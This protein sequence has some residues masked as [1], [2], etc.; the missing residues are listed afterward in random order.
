ML[1][2]LEFIE[3]DIV[4]DLFDGLVGPVEGVSDFVE[5]PLSFDVLSGFVSRSND[6]HE[7]SFMDLSIFE[8]PPVLY[9]ITLSTPPSPTSHIFDINDEIVL[10]DSDDD[11]SSASDLGPID[12]RVSLAI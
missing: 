4:D 2:L 3:G 8:Y 10:H 7:S 5:P 9:D 11:S 12:Q 6:V 1:L